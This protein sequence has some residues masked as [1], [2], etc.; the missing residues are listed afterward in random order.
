MRNAAATRIGGVHAAGGVY[1]RVLQ[2]AASRN[3][4]NGVRHV[5]EKAE[6]HGGSLRCTAGTGR[7]KGALRMWFVSHAQFTLPARCVVQVGR[8]VH[9][10]GRCHGLR[11]TAM[12]ADGGVR[13]APSRRGPLPVPA[14]AK[15]MPD[16][17]NGGRWKRMRHKGGCG[18]TSGGT[19]LDRHDHRLQRHEGRE[20]CKAGLA[21]VV[22]GAVGAQDCVFPASAVLVPE[23]HRIPVGSAVQ[24]TPVDLPVGVA[25]DEV[26]APAGEREHADARGAVEEFARIDFEITIREDAVVAPGG[27]AVRGPE[28]VNFRHSP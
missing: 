26:L 8:A 3:A 2:P 28:A 5:T 13:R 20:V 27:A 17:P 14:N 16:G 7:R 12:Q 11:C 10:L 24:L 18:G 22:A 19:R 1:N 4:P 6:A 9:F 15:T 21:V 25:L 23:V